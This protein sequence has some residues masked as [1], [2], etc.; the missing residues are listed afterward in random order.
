MGAYFDFPIRRVDLPRV[1]ALRLDMGSDFWPSA[2]FLIFH[3]AMIREDAVAD[4][5]P[6][7]IL[8]LARQGAKARG[9]YRLI[10]SAVRV[11]HYAPDPSVLAYLDRFARRCGLK[12]EREAAVALLAFWAS[13]AEA[14]PGAPMLVSDMERGAQ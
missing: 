6:E 14:W 11:R 1:N 7:S 10:S 2:A 13:S 9:Y 3:S 4:R 8:D 5:V 12:S